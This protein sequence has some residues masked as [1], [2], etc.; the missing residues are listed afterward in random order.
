MTQKGGS[1][2]HATPAIP[3]HNLAPTQ[4]EDEKS[5]G[6]VKAT[7][8]ATTTTAKQKSG[9]SEPA[10]LAT[11]VFA[12]EKDEGCDDYLNALGEV[13][14]ADAKVDDLAQTQKTETPMLTGKVKKKRKANSTIFIRNTMENIPVIVKNG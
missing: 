14:A 11:P 2:S 9:G 4:E 6:K 12:P 3:R 8:T 1:G 13:E 5:D 10:P 7:P